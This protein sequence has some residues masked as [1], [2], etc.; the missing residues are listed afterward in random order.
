[1]WWYLIERIA[2]CPFPHRAMQRLPRV[3]AGSV[4]CLHTL[5]E[6]YMQLLQD[7]AANSRALL[8]AG[9]YRW[10]SVWLAIFKL[11][12]LDRKSRR[13]VLGFGRELTALRCSA[14]TRL[15]PGRWADP[16][17]R[18]LTAA[19]RMPI[20][21]HVVAVTRLAAASRSWLRWQL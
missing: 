10:G 18:G 4:V 17:D 16:Q 15:A 9:D 12:R 13:I 20:T 3:C 14:W 7:P 6:N 21:E 2:L 11:R 8:S 19:A 5:A 1:M